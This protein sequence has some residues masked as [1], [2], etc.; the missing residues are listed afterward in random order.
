MFNSNPDLDEEHHNISTGSNSSDSDDVDSSSAT[1]SPRA[2]AEAHF[3]PQ[4]LHSVGSEEIESPRSTPQILQRC[5]VGTPPI[6][7]PSLTGSSQVEAE[8]ELINTAAHPEVQPETAI[9]TANVQTSEVLSVQTPSTVDTPMSSNTSEHSESS[10][11]F[12]APKSSILKHSPVREEVQPGGSQTSLKKDSHVQFKKEVRKVDILTDGYQDAE[13]SESVVDINDSNEPYLELHSNSSLIVNAMLH[14]IAHKLGIHRHDKPKSKAAHTR[15]TNWEDECDIDDVLAP[16]VDADTPTEPLVTGLDLTDSDVIVEPETVVGPPRK[17]YLSSSLPNMR[18]KKSLASDMDKSISIEVIVDEQESGRDSEEALTSPSGHG[19]IIKEETTLTELILTVL[20]EIRASLQSANKDIKQAIGETI[21]KLDIKRAA[22]KSEPN[23]RVTPGLHKLLRS[24]SAQILKG[25]EAGD[26]RQ[27]R[28]VLTSLLSV[29]SNSSELSGYEADAEDD[30]EKSSMFVQTSDDTSDEQHQR[31]RAIMSDDT[32]GLPGDE[33]KSDAFNRVMQWREDLQ[34]TQDKVDSST[35]SDLSITLPTPDLENL[36]NTQDKAYVFP[37]QLSNKQV[38]RLQE[39]EKQQDLDGFVFTL[40]KGTDAGN[41]VVGQEKSHDVEIPSASIL[42]HREHFKK[43]SHVQFK[44]DV[45]KVDILTDGSD[46]ADVTTSVV[47]INDEFQ[48][49]KP[50]ACDEDI[51]NQVA[52]YVH[53]Q[54]GNAPAVEVDGPISATILSDTMINAFIKQLQKRSSEDLKFKTDAEESTFHNQ[55]ETVHLDLPIEEEHTEGREGEAI[56]KAQTGPEEGKWKEP[57]SASMPD[58]RTNVPNAELMGKSVSVEVIMDDAQFDAFL[59]SQ[60]KSQIDQDESAM[61]EHADF[62]VTNKILSRVQIEEKLP[63][64]TVI[65]PHVAVHSDKI[66]TAEELFSRLME[67][68]K[69]PL[70]KASSTSS[71][72]VSERSSGS[73]SSQSEKRKAPALSSESSIISVS[74]DLSGRVQTHSSSLSSDLSDRISATVP[75]LADNVQKVSIETTPRGEDETFPDEKDAESNET[76]SELDSIPSDE[77]MDTALVNWIIQHMSLKDLLKEYQ[78]W[79]ESKIRGFSKRKEFCQGNNACSN[80]KCKLAGRHSEQLHSSSAPCVRSN[81][82]KNVEDTRETK[83]SSSLANKIALSELFCQLLLIEGIDTECGDVL[84]PNSISQIFSDSGLSDEYA[85][86]EH[87]DTTTESFADLSQNVKKT[88]DT[89]YINESVVEPEEIAP[90]VRFHPSP[91]IPGSPVELNTSLILSSM[92]KSLEKLDLQLTA[93]VPFVDLTKL[94]FTTYTTQNAREEPQNKV[95]KEPIDN[96]PARDRLLQMIRARPIEEATN[97]EPDINNNFEVSQMC[98]TMTE[99][100]PGEKLLELIRFVGA[101]DVKTPLDEENIVKQEDVGEEAGKMKDDDKETQEIK[102]KM[103]GEVQ[104]DDGASLTSDDTNPDKLLK[105]I[106]SLD[107]IGMFLPTA[108]GHPSL[109]DLPPK[110]ETNGA[111]DSEPCLAGDWVVVQM[112]DIP[113]IEVVVKESAG[114]IIDKA[115]K[116]ENKESP[117]NGEQIA[118]LADEEVILKESAEDIIDKAIKRVNKESPQNDEQ[119]AEFT[120]VEAVLK[121]SAEDSV[122]HAI[123]QEDKDHEEE[124]IKIH[125][126]REQTDGEIEDKEDTKMVYVIQ[127]IDTILNNFVLERGLERVNEVN[128]VKLVYCSVLLICRLFHLV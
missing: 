77:S 14:A 4:G 26:V 100:K 15:G 120:D 86:D 98:E 79:K 78:N 30:T 59:D 54:E 87:S 119:I 40:N 69:I 109:T 66:R 107:K 49:K 52:Q 61:D 67:L 117:Q 73:R 47:C 102:P 93:G 7:Q 24:A 82:K 2:L 5:T 17:E 68:E 104:S 75:P 50:T 101:A 125:V 113:E 35:D 46:E 84:D 44:D 94:P 70:L 31:K 18:S 91:P 29:A 80:I 108:L 16:Y 95:K 65:H 89:S 112:E 121:E 58:M 38:L 63:T 126:K 36:H 34:N 10:G 45:V 92:K 115:I 85:D 9:K 37:K 62:G 28:Q 22:C 114:D 106:R 11:R 71:S 90:E 99:G 81:R 105:L 20:L 124:P 21:Q 103:D 53:E 3:S 64:A 13:V 32:I 1:Y 42:K 56:G 88:E 39:E 118:D 43:D 122:D 127:E 57:L 51:L 6:G 8:M 83:S 23:M 19:F 96:F 72:N 110:H 25:T 74:T 123:E 116:R 48:H 27:V 41:L 97:S 128:Q 12:P 60:S 111:P 33:T 76:T 55:K